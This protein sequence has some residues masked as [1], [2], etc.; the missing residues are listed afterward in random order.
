MIAVRASRLA[1]P[2]I[3]LLLFAGSVAATV[4][5]C[6]AMPDGM[7]GIPMPGGWSMSMAWLP[8]CGR[9][10][11][12]TAA[13]FLGMWTVMMVAM[14]LPV[15]VPMLRRYRQAVDG[16][17]MTAAGLGR[18]TMLAG[19]AYFCVWILVGVAVFPLGAVLATTMPVLPVL[20]RAMPAAGGVIVLIA[21]ISQFT[22]WKA[23]QLACCRRGHVGC[24][25]L[26]ADA[27]TAWRHGLRLGLHCVRCCA[28]PTA[29]LLVTG[30]MDPI[31]M[32][33]VALA[34]AAERLAPDGESMARITGA[35]AVGAGFFLIVRAIAL[36]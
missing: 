13:S 5:W 16:A 21:G 11:A 9:S 28:G 35:L 3:A 12:G 15:L 33:V 20:A 10:W 18:L 1:F 36:S 32:L 14:M 23:R 8:L 2:G 27:G 24:D 22:A 7:A 4:A 26:P 31:A 19:L 29:V 17:G 30:V 6:A 34:I 25:R